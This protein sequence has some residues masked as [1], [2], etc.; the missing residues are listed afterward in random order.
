MFNDTVTLFCRC[1]AAGGDSFAR[2]VLTGVQMAE[3]C[4][5]TAA[6]TLANAVDR[7]QLLLP[8]TACGGYI[9]PKEWD[10]LTPAQ[11]AGHFTLRPGD[12]FVRGTVP[13]DG[14][15]LSA[16]LARRGGWKISSVTEQGAG[17]AL[18]HFVAGAGRLWSQMGAIM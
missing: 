2:T 7:A 3:L 6:G 8:M 17:G 12:V 11:R 1:G 4:G 9:A 16:Y 13:D 5:E 18:H 14:T 10:A 15:P